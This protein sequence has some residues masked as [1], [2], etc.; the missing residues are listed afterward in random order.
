MSEPNSINFLDELTEI[1]KSPSTDNMADI[2]SDVAI[3]KDIHSELKECNPQCSRHSTE[4]KAIEQN[5][6][7]IKDIMEN[8]SEM[9]TGQKEKINGIENSTN[10]AKVNLEEGTSEIEVAEQYQSNYT[11]KILK[12]GGTTLVFG[13][14]GGGVGA[15]FGPI[16]GLIGGTLGTGTGFITGYGSKWFL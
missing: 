6:Y 12:I 10:E 2:N 5:L 16:T 15:I 11:S 9:I 3:L 4:I 14:I 8:M 13:L 1:D 7:D